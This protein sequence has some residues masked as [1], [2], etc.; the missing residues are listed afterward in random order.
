MI[1]LTLVVGARPNFMKISPIIHE[2]NKINLNGRKIDFRLVHTGQHYDKLMSDNFFEQLNIPLPDINFNCSAKTQTEQTSCIMVE[3]EKELT[4]NKPDCVI[5]VGDVNSTM[6]CAIVAKKLNIDV[7]HIEA[8]IRS[9]DR[10]MPEEIN[11]LLTDSISDYFFTTSEFANKNL[12]NENISKNKIFFVGNTMIDCLVNN[13][14]HVI[15]P[16]IEIFEK[17]KN[18]KYF[19]LT[20][21]RPSNV[22]DLYKLNNILK[23]IDDNTEN[24]PILFPIHPRTQ[25]NLNNFGYKFKNIKIIEPQKYLEFIFL[26]KNSM[27]IITDSGGITEESTFLNIPCLTLRNSTERPETVEYGTNIL[28]GD[29]FELLKKSIKTLIDGK[30]KTG[31]V[32]ELWDG[33]TS[34]R[35]INHILKIYEIKKNN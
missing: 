26:I 12:V 18:P 28:I 33:L 4:N 25:K 3:F 30:W 29:N 32:P 20:L 24:T 2:I 31:K 16:D 14:K 5:V 17:I 1:K 8:G 7:A 23:I 15:K 13:L 35:I 11:R 21:H 10:S 22:D 19:I 27:G 9:N 6:A 34:K